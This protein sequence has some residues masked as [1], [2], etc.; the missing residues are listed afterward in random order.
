MGTGIVVVVLVV[1]HSN[2]DDI[3][4][5]IH[6]C[7]TRAM[8]Y[9]GVRIGMSV[10]VVIANAHLCCIAHENRQEQQPISPN[11]VESEVWPIS[12]PHKTF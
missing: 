5:R 4:S 2:V 8:V 11:F 7:N 6:S 1:G 12:A 10:V 3:S 9:H